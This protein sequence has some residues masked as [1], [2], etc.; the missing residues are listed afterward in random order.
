MASQEGVGIFRAPFADNHHVSMAPHLRIGRRPAQGNGRATARPEAAIHGNARLGRRTKELVRRLDASDIAIIDHADLDRVAAEV[1]VA[2]G[3]RAV[4]YVAPAV[5]GRYPN[6]GP[7][8]LAMAGVRLIDAP[9]APLFEE[10]REGDPVTV[11]GG[12]VR[13]N[14]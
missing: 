7:L 4:V 11:V 12:E 8:L 13:R 6:A 3:V 14:G 2:S 1:L 9:V 5:T 10:L